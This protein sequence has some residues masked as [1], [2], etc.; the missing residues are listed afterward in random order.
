MNRIPKDKS[1]MK[2][3][4]WKTNPGGGTTDYAI[5]IFHKA[6]L[7]ETYTS[8]LNK[9]TMLPMMYIDD[10]I[11]ATIEIMNSNS[12]NIKIRSSYNITSMSFTPE[13][14]Y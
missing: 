3:I 2:I 6:I 10:A 1:L 9:N 4:S 7:E 14:L 5:E 12:E 11:D 13:D 8:F